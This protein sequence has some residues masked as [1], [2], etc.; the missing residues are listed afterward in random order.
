MILYAIKLLRCDSSYRS[1][2][3]II[4]ENV[5]IEFDTDHQGRK[6]NSNI[7]T[8]NLLI[9]I[10]EIKL[11]IINS[12]ESINVNKHSDKSH[13]FNFRVLNYVF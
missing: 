13:R 7:L 2:E 6:Y 9:N 11:K 4:I 3:F 8:I 1:V 5:F 12:A 10:K